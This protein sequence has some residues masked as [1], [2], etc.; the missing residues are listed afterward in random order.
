[1]L[2]KQ[3]PVF[4]KHTCKHFLSKDTDGHTQLP[5][6]TPNKFRPCFCSRTLMKA[7]CSVVSQYYSVFSVFIYTDLGVVLENKTKTIPY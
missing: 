7:I 1:M 5:V 2:Y 3:E 6:L 4:Q